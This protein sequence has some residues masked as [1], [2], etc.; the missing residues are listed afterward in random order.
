M[1]KPAVGHESDLRPQKS[2]GPPNRGV[3][4]NRNVHNREQI[5]GEAH[6]AVAAPDY[7]K[8]TEFEL[9]QLIEGLVIATKRV[10]LFLA[11][12]RLVSNEEYAVRV[13]I[14]IVVR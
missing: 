8:K 6:H 5:V 4:A 2:R 13:A 11:R 10:H 12:W 14:G 9:G 1:A 3:P 7:A